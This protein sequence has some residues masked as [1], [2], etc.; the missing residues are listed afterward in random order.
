M[1]NFVAGERPSANKFNSFFSYLN[2]KLMFVGLAVGDLYGSSSSQLPTNKWGRNYSNNNYSTNSTDN[3]QI[4]IISLANLIGPASNLNPRLILD[5]SQSYTIQNETIP[6][7]VSEYQLKAKYGAVSNITIP[8]PYTRVYSFQSLNAD[9]EF[10]YDGV[11]GNLY[12]YKKTTT[13]LN[14]NYTCIFVNN[15]TNYY[16]ASF[17]VIPDPNTFEAY[18]ERDDASE[19]FLSITLNPVDNSYTVVLPVIGAQQ[20][21]IFDNQTGGSAILDSTNPNFGK[22]IKLPQNII[23]FYVGENAELPIPSNLIVLKCYTTNEVFKDATYYYVNEKTIRIANLSI[24]PD[25]LDNDDFVLI[26]NGTSITS[27]ID[28]LNVKFTKHKHDGSFGDSKISITNIADIFSKQDDEFKYFPSSNGIGMNWMP[29][30]LH[31]NGW[32]LNV[33][34]INDDNV[35]RGPLVLNQGV[36]LF[37]KKPDDADGS[38]TPNIVGTTGIYSIPVLIFQTFNHFLFIN[39]NQSIIVESFNSYIKLLADAENYILMQLENTNNLIKLNSTSILLQHLEKV[40]VKSNE[41]EYD[42]YNDNV[43][44]KSTYKTESETHYTKATIARNDGLIKSEYV[45][46]GN[47][48]PVLLNDTKFENILNEQY[49]IVEKE[50]NLIHNLDFPD[51]SDD[52]ITYRLRSE[53]TKTIILN[54]IPTD[55]SD[56]LSDT[57]AKLPNYLIPFGELS[58]PSLLTEK[59]GNSWKFTNDLYGLAPK[60]LADILTFQNNLREKLLNTTIPFNDSL[61]AYKQIYETNSLKFAL[62]RRGKALSGDRGNQNDS[63]LLNYAVNDNLKSLANNISS[64]H[65]DHMIAYDQLQHDAGLDSITRSDRYQLDKADKFYEADLVYM[66][67]KPESVSKSYDSL[68]INDIDTSVEVRYLELRELQSLIHGFGASSGNQSPALDPGFVYKLFFAGTDNDMTKRPIAGWNQIY[69]LTKTHW[70]RESFPIIR[71]NTAKT[72]I[73]NIDHAHNVDFITGAQFVTCWNEYPIV[74]NPYLNK[75]F[76]RYISNRLG[77]LLYRTQMLTAYIDVQHSELNDTSYNYEINFNSQLAALP[78]NLDPMGTYD[79]GTFSPKD[80]EMDDIGGSRRHN[81][82][83]Q[84]GVGAYR[85]FYSDKSVSNSGDNTFLNYDQNVDRVV[86][87]GPAI[88]LIA[89]D[90]DHYVITATPVAMFNDGQGGLLTFDNT[91]DYFRHSTIHANL[92]PKTYRVG[93]KSKTKILKCDKYYGNDGTVSSDYTNEYNGIFLYNP[94]SAGLIMNNNI[95]TN[96]PTSNLAVMTNFRKLT[97]FSGEQKLQ[98]TTEDEFNSQ[99]NDNATIKSQARRIPAYAAL[100]YYDDLFSISPNETDYYSTNFCWDS[101]FLTNTSNLKVKVSIK[102]EYALTYNTLEDQIQEFG[103]QGLINHAESDKENLAIY[104]GTVGFLNVNPTGLKK[105]RVAYVETSNPVY[106]KETSHSKIDTFMSFDL[107]QCVPNKFGF[108]GDNWPS[109]VGGGERWNQRDLFGR[110]RYGMINAYS[111]YA[112]YQE[113]YFADDLF[114]HPSNSDNETF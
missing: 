5:N 69:R 6:S 1:P 103:E 73:V 104:F 79:Y 90:V 46:L 97:L 49:A 8:A 2:Y 107:N 28:D 57:S 47:G 70:F 22:Q 83:Y 52:P 33:D 84:L 42:S 11:T 100:N 86:Y 30:Y 38:T 66:L 39:S 15:G 76:G 108:T 56:V 98:D 16:G 105:V 94:S 18:L 13:T 55:T 23:D 99:G 68:T 113:K 82:S 89:K 81:V 93:Y 58:E 80:D 36:K 72:N 64:S 88:K 14:I 67:I 63:N 27:S 111:V 9:N 32:S 71:I 91:G 85:Y 7:G 51:A 112:H 92:I 109:I 20:S 59:V 44:I 17:N 19:Y 54:C 25:C 12:F 62:V 37:F 21:N 102:E 3:R 43:K 41:I 26:T 77:H 10:F 60:D 74:T 87:E 78:V 45:D 95:P 50:N 110:N 106:F 53:E 65:R 101:V 24:D 48:N 61:G 96:T 40:Q 75:R 31:R 4:D 114:R 34:E 29:Q 35:M